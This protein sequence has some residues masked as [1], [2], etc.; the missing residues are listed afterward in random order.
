M[1]PQ[2]DSSNTFNRRIVFTII[3]HCVVL[4]VVVG[5]LVVKD[6]TAGN[7]THVVQSPTAIPTQNGM[8][9][10]TAIPN[11]AASPLLFGT[12]LG[13]FTGND[14]VVIFRFYTSIDAADAYSYCA[15]TDTDTSSQ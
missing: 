1:R 7:Q 6:I 13:L 9:T 10:V 8:V 12:N 14:Q 5:V 15:H 11:V 4:L 2:L 3:S